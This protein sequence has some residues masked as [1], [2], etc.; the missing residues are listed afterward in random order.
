MALE[1][2]GVF[3]AELGLPAYRARQIAKW[4]YEAG[5]ADFMEMTN[6]PLSLRELLTNKAAARSIRLEDKRRSIDGTEK[7]LFRLHDGELIESVLIPETQRRT[8]CVS[9]QA[10]CA[11]GCRFCLTAR[12]GLKRNLEAHEIVE[13]ALFAR[14][15]MGPDSP[16]NIVLMGM[17][18]PFEN[19]DN[20]RQ[21]LIRFISPEYLG[22]SRR[23]VTVS[24]SGHAGGIRRLGRTG[25]EVNLAVSLNA[26]TDEVRDRLM[27]INR[28]F[29]L[30]ELMSACRDFPSGQY[31]RITFEYVLLKGVND[32][33]A[34]AS[35]LARLLAGMRAKVNL[36][37]FN[38]HPD[39]S[40]EAPSG[41]E[42]AAFQ[43]ALEEKGLDAPVRKS[44][45]SDILAACGQLRAETENNIVKS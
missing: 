24:T 7:F 31:R 1:E 4:I 36:I 21:A 23:R 42:I 20:V 34:D 9:S 17:G 18:E 39:A 38:P 2:L 3:C 8:L 16:T 19:F 35:R 15:Y 26:T 32:S 27:P 43:S 29:P 41:K 28:K 37:P 40:F 13:Q 10:G 6:L 33:R 11:M 14:G 45:G 12:F 22:I 25:P 30:K 44:R 5:C